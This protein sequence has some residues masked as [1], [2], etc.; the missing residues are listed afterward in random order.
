MGV[1]LRSK[2]NN[3]NWCSCQ[4][5]QFASR[6]ISPLFHGFFP[7]LAPLLE[8]RRAKL[9]STRRQQQHIKWLQ[10]IPAWGNF[11]STRSV[12]VQKEY[13]RLFKLLPA[14]TFSRSNMFNKDYNT[15]TNTSFLCILNPRNGAK[16][17]KS[18]EASIHRVAR[19]IQICSDFIVVAAFMM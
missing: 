8:W 10:P 7:S 11:N 14:E 15:H 18:N 17:N 6:F 19:I 12:H 2:N 5:R 4:P 3:N 16:K 1:N 13:A 9:W